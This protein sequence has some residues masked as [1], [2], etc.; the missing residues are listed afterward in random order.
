MSSAVAGGKVWSFPNRVSGPHPKKGMGR[1]IAFSVIMWGLI[2]A[3]SLLISPSLTK[4]TVDELPTYGNEYGKT[5]TYEPD[6]AT[7]LIPLFLACLG[8]FLATALQCKIK[9]ILGYKA[10]N[11]L[12]LSGLVG[13]LVSLVIIVTACVISNSNANVP[14]P[15]EEWAKATHGYT[16]IT[17]VENSDKLL[18]DAIKPNGEHVQV[19]VYEDGPY[20]YTYEN[21]DQLKTVL[22]QVVEKKIA[23]EVAGK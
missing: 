8:L 6:F 7:V 14:Q 22:N 17:K 19:K 3:T 15:F 2:I 10:I 5:L 13:V 23:Q 9:H 20:K 18:Y 12:E 21:V 4:Y 11:I 16:S 1:V